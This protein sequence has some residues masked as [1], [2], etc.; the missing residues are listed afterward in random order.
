MIRAAFFL[1]LLSLA[2]V[3]ARAQ[4]KRIAHRSHAGSDAAFDP[5][6]RSPDDLGLSRE[7]EDRLHRNRARH[8][9]LA[10]RVAADSAQ[11]VVAPAQNP[12]PQKQRTPRKKSR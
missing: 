9:S 7:T 8:D 1:L 10:A 3:A 2:T 6:R 12:Q 4:T 11:T 5:Q